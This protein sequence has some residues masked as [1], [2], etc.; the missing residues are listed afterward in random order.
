MDGSQLTPVVHLLYK[1]FISSARQIIRILITY[2]VVMPIQGIILYI[3]QVNIKIRFV[4]LITTT[5]WFGCY[6]NEDYFFYENYF[7]IG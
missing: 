5:K 4:P 3:H 2:I 7:N 6:E 1:I